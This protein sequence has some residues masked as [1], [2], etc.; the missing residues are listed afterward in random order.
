MMNKEKGGIGEI[1]VPCV[2]LGSVFAR[3]HRSNCMKHS[4]A[5]YQNTLLQTQLQDCDW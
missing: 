4:N 1:P 3:R 2:L 5:D